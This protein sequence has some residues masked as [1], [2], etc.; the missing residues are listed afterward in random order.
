MF[1]NLLAAAFA[2]AA[3]L[4]RLQQRFGSHQQAPQRPARPFL[5]RLD[6]HAFQRRD[7][8]APAD[9]GAVHE[10]RDPG[11]A[12]GHRCLGQCHDR[13]QGQGARHLRHAARNHPAAGDQLRAEHGVPGLDQGGWAGRRAQRHQ[14]LRVHGQDLRGQLRDQRG[15]AE[16]DPRQERADVSVGLD[17]HLGHRAA[18]EAGENP[19][20][21]A[22]RQ[23]DRHQL[24]RGRSQLRLRDPRHPAQARHGADP[25]PALGWRTAGTSTTRARRARG[26]RRWTSSR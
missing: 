1:R 19:D 3:V 22:G 26:C 23:T 6:Q 10:G 9:P 4:Y 18:R 5:G 8:A 21:N 20:G 16:R 25:H 15:R 2:S 17:R 14:A 13:S 12:R 24:D 7:V 11:G